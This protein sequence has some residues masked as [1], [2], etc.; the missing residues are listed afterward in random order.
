MIRSKTGKRQLA[1]GTV[2]AA[3]VLLP[4][5]AQARAT[6]AIDV[7]ELRV[8]VTATSPGH[9]AAVTFARGGGSSSESDASSGDPPSN[10]AVTFSSGFAFGQCATATA[11]DPTVGGSASLV[12]DVFGDGAAVRTS[13][14]ADSVG[15]DAV[16][17]GTVGLADGVAAA[18]FTLA[19]W[20][21]MTITASVWAIASVTGASP[22]EFADSGLSMTL[23]D[24]DGVGLQFIRI[25]FDAFAWGQFG[26]AEDVETRLVSL[27]Y[28]NESDGYMSGL[29]SGYVSSYAYASDPV[30]AVPEPGSAATLCAGL[31]VL[32]AAACR[33][34]MK[35]AGSSRP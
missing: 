8:A 10:Q 28:E 2:A 13:A 5:A 35:K 29:F 27:S 3:C 26:A 21:R 34:A 11:T 16:G 22:L 25:S 18:A 17:Q 23:S 15:P 33:R 19:P 20:T 30:S 7:T 32:A 31:M 1:A 9:A 4:L 14:F 6:A 24:E 12:G